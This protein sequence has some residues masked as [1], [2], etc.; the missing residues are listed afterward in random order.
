MDGIIILGSAGLAKEFFYYV[1]RSEPRIKDFIFVNDLDDGQNE[2]DI[3]GDKYKVIKDWNFEKKYDFIVAVGKPEI[4]KLLV[5]KAIKSGLK[6]SKTI[7]DPSATVFIDKK[8][9]GL[10][11]MISPGCVVTTNIKLGNYVTLNLNTTV[12]HDTIIGD[13]C[14]TNPG[15]HISGECTIGSMNEFGTGC[16]VRDRL[17]IG[18][19]KT[20][21]AQTAVVKSIETDTIEAYV[22]VPSKEL[23]KNNF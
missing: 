18:C 5:H 2:I 3:N 11:G 9:L 19:N 4:K 10:G 17:I 22:G 6:P 7:V 15:V 16:I 1:K 12:G 20:F 14:T 21:G 23:K 13:Y 8:N